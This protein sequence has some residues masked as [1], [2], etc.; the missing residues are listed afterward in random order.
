MRMT[1]M[2]MHVIR[3]DGFLALYN[4]LSASLCRQMTY[5]LTR[6]AIYETTRDRLSQGNKGPPPFYQKVMMG[7]LGGE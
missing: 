4:G 3:T 2:A 6:F 1:G 7:A 5:S